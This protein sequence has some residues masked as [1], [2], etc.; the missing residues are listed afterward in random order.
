MTKPTK[1]VCAQRGLRSAWA[2][3]QSDQILRCPHGETLGPLLP[4]ECT[5]KTL[6][7]AQADLSHRWEYTHFV[8]FVMPWLIYDWWKQGWL[9]TEAWYPETFTVWAGPSYLIKK[10]WVHPIPDKKKALLHIVKITMLWQSVFLGQT[11][12][13]LFAVRKWRLNDRLMLQMKRR[14]TSLCP[15]SL[16]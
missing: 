1:W 14:L 12:L 9:I 8:G 4:I 11:S 3:A 5:S 7:D 16:Y 10:G 15:E 2:S 6:A 13:E